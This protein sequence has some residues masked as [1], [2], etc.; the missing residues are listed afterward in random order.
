M[1]P[2]KVDYKLAPIMQPRY[3]L[4]YEIAKMQKEKERAEA[5]EKRLKPIAENWETQHRHAAYKV[6]QLDEKIEGFKAGLTVLLE[7]DPL[8]PDVASAW[9]TDIAERLAQE[10]S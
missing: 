10:E 5:D 1:P 2:R 6:H 4:M 9:A 7:H 3:A 8:S